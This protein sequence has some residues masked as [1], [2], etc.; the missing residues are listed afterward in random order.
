MATF[1]SCFFFLWMAFK[2]L[3]QFPRKS[4]S[5]SPFY[6]MIVAFHTYMQHKMNKSEKTHVVSDP[7]KPRYC[8]ILFIL[9]AFKNQNADRMK[10]YTEV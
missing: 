3:S 9:E 1:A 7:S 8:R 6:F 4:I 2:K 5:Y 10:S